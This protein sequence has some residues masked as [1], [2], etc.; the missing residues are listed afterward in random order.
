MNDQNGNAEIHQSE[1]DG[2]PGAD[3]YHC[4]ALCAVRPQDFE[5]AVAPAAAI[6]IVTGSAAIRRDRHRVDG[7]DLRRLRIH[8]IEKRDDL[9]FEWIGD[10]GTGEA[11]GFDGLK[12]AGQPALGQAIDVQQMIIAVDGRGSEC[13]GGDIELWI[14]APISPTS[15]R[16]LVMT[17]APAA[18]A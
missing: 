7:A 2:A 9:L 13:I 17:P 15:I 14:L 4:L 6:E 5:K 16:R 1:S 11:G 12:K 3:L 18:Q 10:V 8:H